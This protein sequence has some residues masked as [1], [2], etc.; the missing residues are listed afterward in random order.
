VIS[1][2]LLPAALNGDGTAGL[3]EDDSA[4]LHD[5][6]HPERVDEQRSGPAR[7]CV[8][9]RSMIISARP[10]RCSVSGCTLTRQSRRPAAQVKVP[11][12]PRSTRH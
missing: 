5:D 9:W 8:R 6:W 11:G 7:H 4:S 3:S 10:A 2:L 1:A 12:T